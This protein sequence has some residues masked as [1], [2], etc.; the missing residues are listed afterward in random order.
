MQNLFNTEDLSD[1][2]DSTS[3]SD[4]DSD[5]DNQCMTCSF[6]LKFCTIHAGQ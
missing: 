5:I 2:S 1:D 4:S 6:F 3:D